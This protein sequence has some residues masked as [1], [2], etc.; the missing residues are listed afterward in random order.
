MAAERCL[1]AAI[2]V[3]LPC[4]GLQVYDDGNGAEARV[5]RDRGTKG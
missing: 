2:R 1:S 5:Q 3:V 4:E